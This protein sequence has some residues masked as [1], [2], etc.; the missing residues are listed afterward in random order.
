[1]N[2]LVRADQGGSVC[3]P[4]FII[5]RQRAVARA[6]Q[7][8]LYKVERSVPVPSGVQ[9]APIAAALLAGA[10]ACNLAADPEIHAIRRRDAGEK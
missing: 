5:K 1:M 7:G 3:H 8:A 10:I 9:G 2:P 6:Q 4:I